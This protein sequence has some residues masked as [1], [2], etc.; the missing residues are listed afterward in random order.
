MEEAR[1]EGDICGL[2]A[3]SPFGSGNQIRIVKQ[4]SLQLKSKGVE[5]ER[6]NPFCNAGHGFNPWSVR[7]KTV[8]C[9]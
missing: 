2:M 5:K 9:N 1:E 4:L 8:C 3:D 7:A 6:M